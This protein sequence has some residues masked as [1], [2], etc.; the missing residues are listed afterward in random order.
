[1]TNLNENLA[2]NSYISIIIFVVKVYKES[3]WS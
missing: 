1:M 3:V 2:G